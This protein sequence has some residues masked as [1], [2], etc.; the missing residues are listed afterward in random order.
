MSHERVQRRL[1]A[2]F[3]GDVAGFSA[4][5]ERDEEGTYTRL[6]NLRREII[7]PRLSEHL[8]RLIKTTGDGFLAEFASPI[9]ALRCALAIQ[10][11]LADVPDALRLRVGLNLGDIIIENGGDVYGEGV[12]VAARLEALAAP[13][14][15]LISEKIYGEVEGKVDA[16]FE[17]AGERQLKN[18]S[19]PVHVYSVRANSSLTSVV[20]GLTSRPPSALAVPDSPSIA[21]LPFTNMSSDPEQEYF[22]DGIAEDIITEL[23]RFKGLVVI[24]RN[25]TFTYKNQSVNIKKVGKELGVKY[26]LEGSVRRVGSRVRIT[27]QL[28]EANAGGHLWAERYDRDLIDVFQLQDEITRSV[29]ATLQTEMLFLEGSLRE[30]PTTPDLHTWGITKKIWKLFYGLTRDSLREARALASDLVEANPESAEGYTLLS[31]ITTHYVFMGFAEEPGPLKIEALRL[32]RQALSLVEDDEHSHWGLGLALASFSNDKF[33]EAEASYRRAIEINPNFSL[34]YG[35]LGLMLAYAGRAEESIQET[36]Y[37]IRLNPRD[38]SIFFRYS[39]LA[40]AHFVMADFEQS[41]KWAQL[42]V[43]RKPDWWVAQALLSAALIHLGRKKEAIDSAKALLQRS[44][45]ISLQ[46]LPIEPVR[47]AASKKQFYE[48]LA[49]AGIP[50]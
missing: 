16:E 12:N 34:G 32:I 3:A 19:R 22:A 33:D 38:P 39:T 50:A 49:E 5:M 30:R 47:P 37:A 17:D 4:L 2:I 42:S 27:T 44:P 1:A 48:A 28:I 24:A 40:I 20:K 10:S 21:V 18:I 26:V 41:R 36:L 45:K 11:D 29:V 15:I 13:G 43:D 7:E 23:S 8:G 6:G 9:A 14:G 25:S 35:S 31:L 46:T